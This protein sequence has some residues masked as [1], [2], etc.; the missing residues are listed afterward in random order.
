MS[1]SY[2]AVLGLPSTCSPADVRRAYKKK[3]LLYHPDKAK[4][5]EE[6]ERNHA[7]FLQVAE[8]YE[9][10]ADEERRKEYDAVLRGEAVGRGRG[11]F[12][13]RAW[14]GG[15]SAGAGGWGGDDAAFE[16]FHRR[17]H[18]RAERSDPFELFNSLFGDT[19]LGAR[20]RG[21]GRAR[22]ERTS[23]GGGGEKASDG[24]GFNLRD[25]FADP[26]FGGGGEVGGGSLMSSMMSGGG[27]GGFGGMGM[28][29]SMFGDM[30]AMFSDMQ[31]KA[32]AGGSGGHF[33]SSTTT[34]TYSGGKGGQT[35]TSSSY[36]KGDGP[37]K[38]VT[39]K[40]LLD[41]QGRRHSTKQI[42]GDDGAPALSGYGQQALGRFGQR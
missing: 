25:P 5:G 32:E 16:E 37:T 3:A 2:Y 30:D 17:M 42:A 27:F 22:E 9:C 15:G 20:R 39:T 40:S 21:G 6:R 1:V 26:F 8:A 34:S 33:Y 13:S 10:L 28:G 14:G 29:G 23:R 35:I 24:F 38:T 12:E 31:R 36:R 19:G 11:G 41:A 4:S 7:K 18:E